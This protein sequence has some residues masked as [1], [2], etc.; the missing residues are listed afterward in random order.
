MDRF[1]IRTGSTRRARYWKIIIILLLLYANRARLVAVGRT[2]SCRSDLLRRA[3]NARSPERPA[4]IRRTIRTFIMF[5]WIIHKRATTRTN[6]ILCRDPFSARFG[7]NTCDNHK[8]TTHY[9]MSCTR[10]SRKP[11]LD[12]RNVHGLLGRSERAKYRNGFVESVRPR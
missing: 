6:N 8:I 5:S 12:D 11:R 2:A 9:I 7:A 1:H 4:P 10:N 3:R